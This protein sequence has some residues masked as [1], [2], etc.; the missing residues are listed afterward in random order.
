[1]ENKDLIWLAGLF[2]GEGC[3][4]IT[5]RKPSY[6]KK[7]LSPT[8]SAK[9]AIQMVH[10]DT[11]LRVKQIVGFGSITKY[12]G[13][14]RKNIIYTWEISTQGVKKLL[15][16]LKPYIFTKLKEFDLMEKFLIEIDWYRS[17]RKGLGLGKSTTI[18]EENLKFR[19]ELFLEMS[20][21]KETFKN[22]NDNYIN[23]IPL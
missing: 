4:R 19:E 10:E 23:S 7:A 5:K 3:I 12:G 11:I 17:N 18:P 20:K 21:L 9:M 8:Y 1:M 22:R 6:C 15:P 2:D 16:L 13:K 14:N